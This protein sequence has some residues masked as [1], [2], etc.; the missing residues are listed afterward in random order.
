MANYETNGSAK[1]LHDLFFGRKNASNIGVSEAMSY[2]MLGRP[3]S[4]VFSDI[5]VDAKVY[6]EDGT[7]FDVIKIYNGQFELDFMW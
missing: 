3:F 4:L 5:G 7:L 6:D 2:A 1:L